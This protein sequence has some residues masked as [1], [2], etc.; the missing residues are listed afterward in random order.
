MRLNGDLTETCFC[1]FFS[2]MKRAQHRT[3]NY[4]P[5]LYSNIS[6]TNYD[7]YAIHINF[8][9]L[10]FIIIPKNGMRNIWDKCNK[11][12]LWKSNHWIFELTRSFKKGVWHTILRAKGTYCTD[13]ITSHTARTQAEQTLPAQRA[14]RNSSKTLAGR[15]RVWTYQRSR[16]SLWQGGLLLPDMTVCCHFDSSAECGMNCKAEMTHFWF[17]ISSAPTRL[18]SRWRK[19]I[20]P[21]AF[22]LVWPTL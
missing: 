20:R 7:K 11:L 18:E 15:D 5:H 19:R 9:P 14:L 2:L 3:W 12:E 6:G 16:P 13:G 8:V 17:C 22:S 21:S 10:L 1:F 4:W